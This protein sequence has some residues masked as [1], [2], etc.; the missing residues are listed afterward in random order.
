MYGELDR[1]KRMNRTVLV[2]ITEVNMPKGIVWGESATSSQYTI[3]VAG[4]DALVAI[5]KVGERWFID[6]G[7]DYLW[8]LGKRFE[9]GSEKTPIQEL[10]EG[11]RRLEG[12]TVYISGKQGIV[13]KS[14]ITLI[15]Q[16]DVPA[17]ADGVTLYSK[18]GQLLLCT[19]DGQVWKVALEPLESTETTT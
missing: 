14:Q 10:R 13:A 3:A 9:N 19:P 1:L 4:L 17:R 2:K 16:T 15:D 8:R 18:D 7:Q 12:E 5:P 6:C 11:D